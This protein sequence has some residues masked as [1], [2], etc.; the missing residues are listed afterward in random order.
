ME[1][2]SLVSTS[3][4]CDLRVAGLFKI[5]G[6]VFAGDWKEAYETRKDI[7]I[8]LTVELMVLIG[9]FKSFLGIFHFIGGGGIVFGLLSDISGDRETADKFYT[10]ARSLVPMKRNLIIGMRAMLK[11]ASEWI[12]SINKSIDPSSTVEEMITASFE[13]S[14]YRNSF[15]SFMNMADVDYDKFAKKL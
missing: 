2:T 10:V 3:V 12:S 5:M 7:G 14:S 11:S 15:K 1:C 9:F 8:R 6:S 4:Y 13:S